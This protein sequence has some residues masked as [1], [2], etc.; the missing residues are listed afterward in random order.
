[1]AQR[2]AAHEPQTVQQD[3]GC[4]QHPALLPSLSLAE[5]LTSFLGFFPGMRSSVST[6]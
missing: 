3:M 1:M 2:A 5:L 4:W 6:L